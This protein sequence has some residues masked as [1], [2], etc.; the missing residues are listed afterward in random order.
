[1]HKINRGTA[2][3]LPDPLRAPAAGCGGAGCGPRGKELG[4]LL[5]PPQPLAANTNAKC[6]FCFLPFFMKVKILFRFLLVSKN[7]Y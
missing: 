4:P 7:R 5:L 2:Q 3:M 6:S 1:M